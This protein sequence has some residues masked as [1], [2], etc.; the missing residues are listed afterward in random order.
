MVPLL[1]VK[2]PAPSP[3][4]IS[5]SPIR[6]FTRRTQSCFRL[7][8][9]STK[10]TISNQDS[11][12]TFLTPL[13]DHTVLTVHSARRE[14]HRWIHP[15][16][17]QLLEDT[18]GSFNVVSTV[19]FFPHCHHG[20]FSTNARST[21]C[22]LGA[23]TWRIICSCALVPRANSDRQNRPMSFRFPMVVK[24]PICRPAIN[25]VNATNTWSSACKVSLLLSLR[26]TLALPA[27]LITTIRTDVSGTRARY[28]LLIFLWPALMSRPWELHSYHEEQMSIRIKRLLSPDF[29]QVVA[30]L[31]SFP[32]RLTRRMLSQTT[33]GRPHHPI[34]PTLAQTMIHLE[35]TVVFTI[36]TAEHTL[37][38]QLL[39]ITWLYI[40]AAKLKWL[41]VHRLPPLSLPQSWPV[42]IKSA[43]PPT[44]QPS[45]LWTR[46]SMQMPVPF[47]TLSPAQILAVEQMGLA[48]L[49]DGIQWLDWE[50]R[51]IQDC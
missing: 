14:I 40:S 39:V 41:A 10:Q 49:K 46:R 19:C 34:R 51:T 12:T 17:T 5:R 18:R 32:F 16:P 38:S 37:M 22:V 3:T 11:W 7:M 23:M 9:P 2:P 35:R 25:S 8:T 43:L 4:L 31:T 33:F 6:L 1:Q 48:A 27:L 36:P 44:K 20:C 47:T 28:F 45:A 15:I 30:S 50:P 42:S 24:K 13:M 29:L 26:V 21:A